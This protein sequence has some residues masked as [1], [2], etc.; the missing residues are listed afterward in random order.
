MDISG[1]AAPRISP[2]ADIRDAELYFNE[3]TAL[4][5]TDLDTIRVTYNNAFD[6]MR[7]LRGMGETNILN[8]TPSSVP[9]R[10]L[11]PRAASF[12]TN[13]MLIQKGEFLQHFRFYLPAGL[14]IN[15]SR[16]H[17]SLG[18]KKSAGKCTEL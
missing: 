7:E 9:A 12:I 1:G 6:L 2:F 3:Q 11:F 4:P 16:S 17:S 8:S 18:F 13:D 10:S 14:L 5:V 15:L